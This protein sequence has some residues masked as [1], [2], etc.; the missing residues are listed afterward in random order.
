MVYMV[1]V[2]HQN[3][4]YVLQKTIPTLTYKWLLKWRLFFFFIC[5][6]SVG[7]TSRQT[8]LKLLEL[9]TLSFNS[10]AETAELKRSSCSVVGLQVS[11]TPRY[12]PL[13]SADFLQLLT[14]KHKPGAAKQPEQPAI[15]KPMV[16][17]CVC[18]WV[19]I[20][21]LSWRVC[22]VPWYS[23]SFLWNFITSSLYT[24]PLITSSKLSL[25]QQKPKYEQQ[26]NHFF[27]LMLQSNSS[28]VT[29]SNS[30]KQVC[31]KSCYMKT[32]RQKD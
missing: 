14:R 29:V 22:G 5:I 8:S 16:T 27:K 21:V 12:A 11:G 23:Y 4:K 24:N 6:F 26:H 30:I 3:W 32:D 15:N 13:T 1:Y 25:W 19:S 7:E 2:D 28:F 17:E 18:V 31:W 20:G 9:Y 10:R